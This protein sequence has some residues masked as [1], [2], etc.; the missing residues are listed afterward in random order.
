MVYLSSQTVGNNTSG[1]STGVAGSTS[2][3]IDTSTGMSASSTS[4][5]GVTTSGTSGPD[6]T[7][8]PLPPPTGSLASKQYNAFDSFAITLTA[9]ILLFYTVS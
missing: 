3:V 2:S 8:N 7:N 5:A 6:N 4:A 9:L 1:N